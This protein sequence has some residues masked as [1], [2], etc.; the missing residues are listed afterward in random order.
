MINLWILSICMLWIPT[1]LESP[2]H[3]LYISLTEGEIVESEVNF[4]VKVF[5][6]DLQDAL[7]NHNSSS[8]QSGNL[9]EFYAIN[10][11]IAK[12]YFTEHF[13]LWVADQLIELRLGDY[14]MEGDAHFIRIT[15]SLPEN[16][17]ELSVKA[18][19]LMELFPTQ[20][21]VVK[22]K[23]GEQLKYLRFDN[24]AAPQVLSFD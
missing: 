24:P 14:T 7:R 9:Q 19:Y 18:S 6:D 3:A 11:A 12:D 22:V 17:K 1:F 15:G 4:E 16:V 21:N 20:I 5:S 10:E 23:K 8:Y 2:T 13:K